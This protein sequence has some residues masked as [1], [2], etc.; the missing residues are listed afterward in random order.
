MANS[1]TIHPPRQ[2]ISFAWYQEYRFLC[3]L[4][5]LV[6]T[7]L[8]APL[9]EEPK[10]VGHL[11]MAGCFTLIFF[12]GVLANRERP[13]I[14]YAAIALATIGILLAWSR[15]LSGNTQ[16]TLLRLIMD[17]IF[18][19]FTAIMIL[20]AVLKDHMARRGSIVGAICV[21]LL[22]GLTWACCYNVIEILD[23]QSFRYSEPQLGPTDKG[24]KSDEIKTSW[25]R[26][27]YYSFVTMSTLGFGD[28]APRT[29]LAQTLTWMQ[30][31]TGQLY[32]V[33]LIARLVS[34]LPYSHDVRE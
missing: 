1:P 21:Y 9:M 33:V 32:L 3:L 5:A 18:F 11:L 14:F 6:A 8:L 19:A 16:L 15:L 27:I 2:A 23:R 7:L 13:S 10:L 28:I 34:V 22:M 25:P 30:A 31:V 12:T 29:P 20:I 17:V 24:E 4:V 26:M